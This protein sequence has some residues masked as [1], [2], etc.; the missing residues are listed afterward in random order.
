MQAIVARLGARSISRIVLF[1]SPPLL[2]T[3]ESRVIA[4]VVGQIV[5][6]VRAGVTPQPAVLEAI[7][8]LG[9]GKPIGLVLNQSKANAPGSYYGYGA[10]GYG[11][12]GSAPGDSNTSK[13]R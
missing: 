2:L 9:E 5:M 11:A 13:N 12:Y 8:F 7:G 4:T 1:D 10:Y 3:N 6:V